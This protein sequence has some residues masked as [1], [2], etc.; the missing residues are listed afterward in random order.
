MTQFGRGFTERATVLLA[1]RLAAAAWLA[2][3]IA[4]ALHVENAYWAAMPVFVVTQP[5]R[6]LVFER[7][8][9]RVIGTL[10]GAGFGFAI[11][12]SAWPVLE[13]CALAL[14]IAVCVAATHIV[15][16][17]R[18][19]AFVLAAMTA[20]IVVLPTLTTPDRATALALARV[21]CTLIGVATVTLVVGLFT[22]GA[23]RAEFY[24]RLRALAAAAL[25]LAA[26]ASGGAM[27]DA[28]RGGR[29]A[30]DLGALDAQ[31]RMIAAGSAAGWRRL[32]H[33][34]AVIAAALAV[35]SSALALAR[36]RS[37]GT[38]A[39]PDLAA[40]LAAAAR[41]SRDGEVADAP[42]PIGRADLQGPAARL[43]RASDALVAAAI[44]LAAETHQPPPSFTADLFSLAPDSDLDHA[45]RIGIVAGSAALLPSIVGILPGLPF[46]TPAALGVSIF[47]IVLGSMPDP[48]A[49][50][51]K[52]IV[53]VSIGVVVAILFRLLLQPHLVGWGALVLGLAPF[54]LVGSFGRA[55]PAT[56]IP[57]IDANM[58]FLLA[59][60]VG[61]TPAPLPV[62]LGGAAALVV[63]A[64]LVGGGFYIVPLP[65]DRAAEAV[66]AR[67]RGDLVALA[68][69]ARWDDAAWRSEMTRE[70]LSL[71]NGP[72]RPGP[73]EPRLA[74]ALAALDLGH[75]LLALRAMAGLR[76]PIRRDAAL[77]ALAAARELAA[78]LLAQQAGEVG[79]TELAALIG[80]A[81]DGIV[82]A[83]PLLDARNDTFVARLRRTI[84]R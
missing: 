14:W 23:A 60:Q 82:A 83:T 78:P 61:A 7:A 51:P 26:D 2:F 33:V 21:E 52:L 45:A 35:A 77:A 68:G 42:S 54:I 53:G 67:V 18:S 48:K 63:S 74:G 1:L 22:P 4:A 57:A 10:V 56:A 29:L 44:A 25:Q 3:A 12:Q 70:I 37:R 75:T 24:A 72:R 79:D 66:A 20:A 31:A 46:A 65:T 19:Y 11:L 38:P 50:A 76:E 71:A 73:R 49:I 15:R 27:P 47:A 59:S 40:A 80:D 8:V 28:A 30:A 5:T 84:A 6:G 62:M 13:L 9:F 16:G 43:A 64:V 69:M 32:A 55:N 39:D 81:A 17:V 58:C 41:W 34:E 36:R